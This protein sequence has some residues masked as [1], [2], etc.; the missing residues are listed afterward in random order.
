MKAMI[1][2]AG[3]GTRLQPWTLEHPKALVPVGGIPMLERVITRL[4]DEGFR[5]IIVNVH[6]FGE[7]IIG[8][9]N[10][11]D[12][13]VK[14]S[15]SDERGRLLDT[16]GGLVHALDLLG[17]EPVLI[18]NVDILSNASL[19]GLMKIHKSSGASATL[20]VSERDSNRKLI[21]DGDMSL[22]GWHNIDKG[23][24]R[25]AKIERRMEKGMPEGWKEYAFSGIYVTS[26]KMRNEMHRLFGYD[27]FPIMDYF[28][29]ERRKERIEGVLADNLDLI[30]IGKPE[31]LAKAE[32]TLGLQK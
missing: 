14:I 9:V 3:L 11:K 25:P 22:Q 8:F 7:Q 17:D 32:L 23:I 15:I 18:H 19:G 20:L 30:D 21:F 5:E 28:L 2:A 29:S 24:F 4:R 26:A 13:G 12:F 27:A 16:G 10:S 1:L 31:T 6:H